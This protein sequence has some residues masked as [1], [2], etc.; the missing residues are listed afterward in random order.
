MDHTKALIEVAGPGKVERFDWGAIQPYVM[1]ITGRCGST[2]LTK[3]LRATGLAGYPREWFNSEVA[4]WAGVHTDSLP[5]YFKQVVLA[6]S[7]DERFGIQ[8]DPSRLSATSSLIDWPSVFK[9][10]STP[11]FFLY[12]RDILSQAWSWV[13][14][15]GTGVWHVGERTEGDVG[16]GDI[17]DYAPMMLEVAEQIVELRRQEE[18]LFAFWDE[19]GYQ[20]HFIEYAALAADPLGT[21]A[22]ILAVLDVPGDAI[23]A[24][25]QAASQIESKQR[26]YE[27]RSAW[28]AKFSS[29]NEAP[30]AALSQDR[31]GVS[32]EY[33]AE[34]LVATEEPLLWPYLF[35]SDSLANT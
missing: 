13:Q 33:L 11:T 23:E 9:P 17:P 2:W 24:A 18:H 35:G 28:L 6:H 14:A 25:I 1:F 32:S 29:L 30:L 7:S 19:H 5:D 21:V 3:L 26:S 34:A 27:N 16:D 20:P 22:D 4:P 12:R 15:V 8:I 10:E 31:F